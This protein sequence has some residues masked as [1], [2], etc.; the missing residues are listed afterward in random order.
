MRR[1][2]ALLPVAVACCTVLSCCSAARVPNPREH[3][4]TP[5]KADAFFEPQGP[6]VDLLAPDSARHRAALG[7]LGTMRK[8]PPGPPPPPPPPPNNCAW[9][10]IGPTN[11]HGRVTDIAIDPT[12]HNRL[13]VSTVGGVW[14]SAYCARRW[15]RVSVS[16]FAGVF[17]S[18]AINPPAEVFIGG[19]DSNAIDEDFR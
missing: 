12:N 17:G 16:I 10:F 3:L 8:Q 6:P 15:D 13:F 5:P 1:L 7:E 11:V 4:L 19:G 14:R 18:V 2:L 9:S